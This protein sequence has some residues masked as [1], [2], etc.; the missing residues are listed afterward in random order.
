MKLGV[1]NRLSCD[2]GMILGRDLEIVDFVD[3]FGDGNNFRWGRM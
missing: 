2:G 1:S 3:V